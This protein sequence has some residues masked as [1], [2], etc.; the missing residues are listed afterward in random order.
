[1]K[2]IMMPTPTLLPTYT[3]LYPH[4]RSPTSRILQPVKDPH[5]V[6][7]RDVESTGLRRLAEARS[8]PEKD[9]VLIATNE[10]SIRI[11]ANLVANLASVGIHHY[12]VLA[13]TPELCASVRGRIACVWS[14]LLAPYQER[15]R[16]IV[17]GP[18]RLYGL[19]LTRQI[20]AGRLALMGFSP[21]ILDSDSIVFHD[22]FKAIAEHLPGYQLYV[23]G[24]HSGTHSGINCGTYY[25]RGV[26]PR[27]KLLMAWTNFERRAF[28][29]LNESKP[30][31]LATTSGK[32]VLQR[33]SNK[34]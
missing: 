21:F 29:V 22:P 26:D 9:I 10:G 13:N 27:G 24:D 25:L 31:P 16:N 34:E 7:Q 12:I 6:L 23:M 2:K 1:M 15:L 30:L 4:R 33:R 11:T 17:T 18:S 3:E 14:T 8:S 32:H 5:A 20:Y 19:W 28:S